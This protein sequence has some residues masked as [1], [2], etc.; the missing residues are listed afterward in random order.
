[1]IRKLEGSFGSNY[2]CEAVFN[3]FSFAHLDTAIFVQSLPTKLLQRHL[4][5]WG[6]KGQNEVVKA[7]SEF[8]AE[9]RSGLCLAFGSALEV[10]ALLEDGFSATSLFPNLATTSLH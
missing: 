10:S 4:T 2:S 5:E 7:S 9:L 3:K 8:S 6:K 1:M